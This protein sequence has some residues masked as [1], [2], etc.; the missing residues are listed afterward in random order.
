VVA[1]A[2]PVSFEQIDAGS[3]YAPEAAHIAYEEGATYGVVLSGRL[4]KHGVVGR[5]P[6]DETDRLISEVL[7]DHRI[8]DYLS[9]PDKKNRT[10]ILF[11]LAQHPMTGTESSV[12]DSSDT[13]AVS[14]KRRENGGSSPDWALSVVSP[15]TIAAQVDDY[16]MRV[17]LMAKD[18]LVSSP[19]DSAPYSAR[20]LE[21]AKQRYENENATVIKRIVWKDEFELERAHRNYRSAI[22]RQENATQIVFDEDGAEIVRGNHLV[23]IAAEYKTSLENLEAGQSGGLVSKIEID[24]AHEH[25]RKAAEVYEWP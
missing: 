2:Q 9:Y 1:N 25:F 15:D 19:D 22:E 17:S 7:E 5:A 24:A 10:I 14:Q 12:P 11:V 23:D 13:N 16:R 6:F 3:P 21:E 8:S 18:E 4:A 20:D